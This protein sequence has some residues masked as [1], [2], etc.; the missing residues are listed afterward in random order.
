MNWDGIFYEPVSPEEVQK[1]I[2]TKKPTIF[3]FYSEKCPKC[4]ILFPLLQSLAP[5]YSERL[6]FYQ[7]NGKADTGLEGAWKIKMY[8]TLLIFVKG[9]LEIR[10][11]G[12]VTAENL[13]NIAEDITNDFQQT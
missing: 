1:L 4:H 13:K 8:P 10:I 6:L 5:R 11:E 3:F 7:I 2:D 12:I 9:Q